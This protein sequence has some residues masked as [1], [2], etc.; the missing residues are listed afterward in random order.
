M[1]T[2]NRRLTRRDALKLGAAGS[3][4][5]AIAACGGAAT[6]PT[7]A[8]AASAVPAAAAAV[9]GPSE[10]LV[11]AAKAEGTLT[12]YVGVPP[13]AI[14]GLTKAFTD[15][16]GINVVVNRQ[17]AATTAPLVKAEVE[18]GKVIGDIVTMSDSAIMKEFADKGWL[19][20]PGEA[21]MPSLKGWPAKF[22]YSAQGAHFMQAVGTYTI[23]YNKQLAGAN[24]P[25]DWSALIDPRWK[26]K[27]ILNN[28]KATAGTWGFLMNLHRAYGPAFLQSLAK[29]D[30]KYGLSTTTDI[31][32]V[33]SGDVAMLVPSSHWNNTDLIAKGAPIEDAY[34]NPPMGGA[35]QWGGVVKGAPH[36]NAALLF[37][38]FSLSAA[39]Q[40]ALCKDL[41]SSVI[42]A[43][44]AMPLPATYEPNNLI[45][46]TARKNE[47]LALI[48]V[49]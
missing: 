45:E 19:T 6:A 24:V 49:Q 41:C 23:A 28:P 14:P 26:G 16:Y 3:A 15:K 33:A 38:D 10:A 47:L 21:D 7:A 1:T 25:K 48:G 27:I 22:A 42:N 12:W 35:E 18:G 39:G 36:P 37:L 17:N 8:P 2:P 30:L 32:S 29:M 46:A 40:S 31:N 20:K 5:L 4:G 9:A 43:P 34:P 11:R 13:P 44:G